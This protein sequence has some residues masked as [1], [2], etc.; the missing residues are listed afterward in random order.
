MSAI[1]NAI[2]GAATGSSGG[3]GGAIAGAVIG[4][5]FGMAGQSSANR[6]N[7]RI[8][9]EQMAFQER[10]SNTAHQREVADLRKAGLNPILSANKGASSP[11]GASIPVKS[12]T[13]S[14]A[15]S[16][17]AASRIKA[18]LDLLK[19]QTRVA[20]AQALKH[21]VD[22]SKSNTEGALLNYK[23]PGAKVEAAIDQ[24]KYGE[25]LRYMNRL[26]GAGNTALSI[27]SGAVGAAGYGVLKKYRKFRS[28][29]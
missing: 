7:R 4:G 13:E 16:A 11:A 27:G 21:F 9:R 25:V 24:G 6:Q 1:D 5:L 20:R 3:T 23:I 18:E 29:K 17:L 14:A 10:M 15:N 22:A 19:Q 26:T 8:A 12:I 2:A 28:K